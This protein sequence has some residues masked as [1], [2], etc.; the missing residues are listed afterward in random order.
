VGDLCQKKTDKEPLVGTYNFYFCYHV[1]RKN[2]SQS[3]PSTWPG[4]FSILK[5]FFKA[6]KKYPGPILLTKFTGFRNN[7]KNRRFLLFLGSKNGFNDTKQ[8]RKGGKKCK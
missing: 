1:F 6:A 8:K 4:K 7:K 2:P 3:C 5:L